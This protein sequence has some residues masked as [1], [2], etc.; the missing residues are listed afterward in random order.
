MIESQALEMMKH[1]ERLEQRMAALEQH[2]QVRQSDSHVNCCVWHMLG[3]YVCVCAAGVTC[4]LG[5]SM[6]GVV[7]LVPQP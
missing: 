4:A 1:N 2:T 3:V 7:R 5:C 6:S